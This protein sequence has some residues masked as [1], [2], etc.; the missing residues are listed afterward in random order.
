M[1]QITTGSSVARRMEQIASINAAAE[2]KRIRNDAASEREHIRIMR[3]LEREVEGSP[4]RGGIL[5]RGLARVRTNSLEVPAERK[6]QLVTS[7]SGRSFHGR[8][9]TYRR[10]DTAARGQS[11]KRASS[12][13]A[14]HYKYIDCV[15]H[16]ATAPADSHVAYIDGS[17]VEQGVDGERLSRSNIEGDFVERM[18]FFE[19]VEQFERQSH[20][21]K[22]STNLNRPSSKLA[23]VYADPTCDPAIRA[24]I[25]AHPLPQQERPLVIQLEG[26]SKDLRRLLKSHRIDLSTTGTNDERREKDGIAFHSGRSGRTHFRWVF[27][28]PVEFTAQQREQVLDGL[29]AH[30]DGLKCMYAAVIHAPDQHNDERNYHLHLIFY[31][32]PCRR[33]NCTQA[34]LENVADTFKGA[35]RKEIEAGEIELGEWDFAVQRRY[36]SNRTWKTHFPFRAEK[37]REVT[38]GKDWQGRFR[39]EYAAIVNK[40]SAE[41]GGPAVYD[42]RSYKDRKV[43]ISPSRHLGQLHKSETAGIPTLLGLSN[44]STQAADERRAAISR[45]ATE[46]ARLDA[47]ERVLAPFRPSSSVHH[48]VSAWA[49]KPLRDLEDARY[50]AEAALAIELWSLETARERS[51]AELVRDRQRR[52]SKKGPARERLQREEL[53][54]VAETC[55]REL[56]RADA[57]MRRVIADVQREMEWASAVTAESVRL[58]ATN[59]EMIARSNSAPLSRTAVVAATGLVGNVTESEQLAAAHGPEQAASPVREP[60]NEPARSEMGCQSPLPLGNS[61]APS[62]RSIMVKGG[63]LAQADPQPTNTSE[64]EP[65]HLKAERQSHPLPGDSSAPPRR[66]IMAKAGVLAQADRQFG[67]RADPLG[68]APTLAVGT[69]HSAK[70]EAV[71]AR[72]TPQSLTSPAQPCVLGNSSSGPAGECLRAARSMQNQVTTDRYEE[73]S[74]SADGRKPL[75]SHTDLATDSTGTSRVSLG[76]EN[77]PSPSNASLRDIP[78][79]DTRLGA[80]IEDHAPDLRADH[81]QDSPA[82]SPDVVAPTPPRTGFRAI[83]TQDEINDILRPRLIGPD[84]VCEPVIPLNDLD[85]VTT[86][87]VLWAY[88]DISSSGLKKMS[89]ADRELH[90]SAAEHPQA[91]VLRA[92]L[93]RRID[94]LKSAPYAA[95]TY[96]GFQPAKAN[97]AAGKNEARRITPQ[98]QAA[99][100]AQQG[101]GGRQ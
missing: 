68:A 95:V 94:Q 89:P 12:P 100:F 18:R 32:R 36:K 9:T 26:D 23:A 48:R 40:V 78:V 90:A 57:Q 39:R 74:A 1:S 58:T 47:L 70:D 44:E 38:R 64:R 42:P 77:T 41:A 19:L 11:R 34:D 91:D 8:G 31:D 63:A 75:H 76:V 62:R 67:D 35:I 53:A 50:A 4:G 33:L 5:K 28:I 61:S 87:K 101:M 14:A 71:P 96:G 49:A 59:C 10:Q 22:V 60:G 73:A 45:H 54:A 52:A 20:G 55:L 21:D 65:A 25:E 84:G 97:S 6:R 85:A 69:G 15:E 86:A 99:L 81:A 56:D 66:N 3:R 72:S 88:R 51:R 82:Q 16:D 17:R 98:Q 24:A 80:P 13:G 83:L 43:D 30:M 37:S 93:A 29:C 2:L 46:M 92:A 27:E 79:G 7:T